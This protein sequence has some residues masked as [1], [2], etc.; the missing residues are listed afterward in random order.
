MA[1]ADIIARLKLNA[2]NFN[3]EMGKVLNEAE[4]KFGGT[5]KVIG[6]NISQGIGGGLQ[7]AASRV[8][9][10]G[11]ALAGL[12]GPALIASAAIGGIVAVLASGVREA[13]ALAKATRQLD[14]VI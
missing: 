6:R 8:P 5:G 10:L 9:V 12:S 7:Q 1:S 13:E 3:G 2:A 14:A 11:G 4:R